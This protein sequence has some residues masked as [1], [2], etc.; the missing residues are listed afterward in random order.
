MKKLFVLLF[1]GSLLASCGGSGYTTDKEDVV[2]GY[3]DMKEDAQ[4]HYDALMAIEESWAEDKKEMLKDYEGKM[5]KLIEKAAKDDDAKGDLKDF[6]NSQFKYETSK[7]E[8]NTSWYNAN[9]GI[10]KSKSDQM[11]MLEGDAK[12]AFQKSIEASEKAISK[13]SDAH[14]KAVDKLNKD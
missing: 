7:G 9:W 11:E 6:R 3:D 14:I 13:I 8:E 2:S 5:S 4:G 10:K 12:K 1:V